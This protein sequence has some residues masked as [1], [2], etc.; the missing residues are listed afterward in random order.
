MLLAKKMDNDA[1]LSSVLPMDLQVDFWHPTVSRQDLSQDHNQHIDARSHSTLS[2]KHVPTSTPVKLNLK[3][4]QAQSSVVFIVFCW[5]ICEIHMHSQGVIAAK[6]A[7]AA[8]EPSKKDCSTW[9]GTSS[10]S[11]LG[12]YI[13]VY[14]YI[15]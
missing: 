14:I 1:Q 13:P 7:A 5:G 4:K 12:C 15:L 3:P 6:A 2:L 8:L 11:E 10:V 9:H